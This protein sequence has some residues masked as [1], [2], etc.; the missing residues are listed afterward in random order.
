[1]ELK[2]YMRILR[3]KAW[4]I[5]AIVVIVC[6]LTGIKSFMFTESVYRASAK[7]IVNQSYSVDGTQIVDYSSVQTNIM[8]ISSYTEI[9]KS[10]AILDKVVSQYPDL[11]ITPN[12]LSGMISV[13]SA[14]DSQVMNLD[15]VDTSY[16]RAV[17]IANAVA[18]V[19]KDQIPS[20]M[21]VDN[22]TILSK[23][24]EKDDAYPINSSPIVMV[25]LSFIVSFML[26]VGLVFLMDY[27]DDTI[28]TEEDIAS[29]L[30][31]PMLAYITKINKSDLAPRRSR[32]NSKQAGENAYVPV[33]QQS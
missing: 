30:E 9:I 29:S 6:V 12:Q 17:S 15:V 3:K 31:L 24:N 1:M 23:A 22:V 21:K 32:S 13:S 16:K 19:F 26:A 7:L 8:L 28:K 4:L 2:Q 20:I 5:S 11:D 14:S 10:A 27:F 33:K 25:I 18:T